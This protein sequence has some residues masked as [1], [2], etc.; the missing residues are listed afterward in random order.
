MA[1]I[2]DLS[3]GDGGWEGSKGSQ[4]FISFD[5]LGILSQPAWPSPPLPGGWNTDNKNFFDVYFAF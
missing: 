4:K 3:D 5:K 2:V 1:G